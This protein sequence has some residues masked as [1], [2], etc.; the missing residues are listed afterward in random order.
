VCKED[1]FYILNCSKKCKK[2]YFFYEDRKMFADT[3]FA[4]F[5]KT[6]KT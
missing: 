6:I 2:G 4:R 5:A 3:I 1:L